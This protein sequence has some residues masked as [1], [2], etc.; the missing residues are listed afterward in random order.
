MQKNGY[1][2]ALLNGPGARYWVAVSA[3][4]VDDVAS[5]HR[6]SRALADDSSIGASGLPV[7]SNPMS[8][9]VPP[10]TPF[11]SLVPVTITSRSLPSASAD[12]AR[13]NG[14][15]PSGLAITRSLHP[16]SLVSSRN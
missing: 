6:P 16:V 3:G 11:E 2:P 10:Y 8:Q 5:E 1:D 12:V 7:P 15:F 4:R 9:M 13:S 14:G